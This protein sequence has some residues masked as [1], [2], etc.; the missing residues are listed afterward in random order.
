[1]LTYRHTNTLEVVAF[2][3]FDYEDYV[4]DKKSTSSYIFRMVEGVVHG[5]VSSRHLQ[6]L[7][8]QR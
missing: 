8:L 3:D 2:S 7:L 6:L 5:K 1:M 4:N